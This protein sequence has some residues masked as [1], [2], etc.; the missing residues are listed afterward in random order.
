MALTSEIGR[1]GVLD[2]DDVLCTNFSSSDFGRQSWKLFKGP[3][4]DG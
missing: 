4:S 3:R 1:A 2:T